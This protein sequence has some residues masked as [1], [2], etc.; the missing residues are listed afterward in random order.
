M[1]EGLIFNAAD[2]AQQGALGAALSAVCPLV[3]M[4]HLQGDLGA[5]KT[6]FVRGFLRGLGY[7]GAVRSPTY[8]LVE[9]YATERLRCYHF[10]LYRL[11]DAEELE[12]LGL[13]DILAEQAVW[14]VEWPEHGAGVLPA[15]DLRVGIEHQRVGRRL[16]FEAGSALGAETL[17]ALRDHLGDGIN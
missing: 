12:Y 14:L 16:C 9:P 8:T 13:R 17:G 15:P 10:D 1:A 7:V 2:E 11:A 5:G 3:C 6:T 4:I